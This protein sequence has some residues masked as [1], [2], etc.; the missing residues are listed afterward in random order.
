MVQIWTQLFRL[1]WVINK[2][3]LFLFSVSSQAP[4]VSHGSRTNRAKKTPNAKNKSRKDAVTPVL[5]ARIV[6]DDKSGTIMEQAR[7][8]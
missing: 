8:R 4:K 3:W 5:P 6:Y 1:L 2:D 7:A